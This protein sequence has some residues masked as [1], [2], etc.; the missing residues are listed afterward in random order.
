MRGL[1]ILL[2]G[3]V[4]FDGCRHRPRPNAVARILLRAPAPRV[5]G[6]SIPSSSS[7]EPL[8]RSQAEYLRDPTFHRRVVGAG[9]ASLDLD[10]RLVKDSPILELV[11]RDDDATRALRRC[12]ALVDLYLRERPWA[13][14]E[15]LL[16][17]TAPRAEV[18]DPCKKI[19]LE[20][21]R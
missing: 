8:L 18:L 16:D 12:Q 5:L 21:E 11:V 6:N 20:L 2:L 7:I 9:E 10:V 17:P 1:G 15:G 4:L 14:G 3:L 19:D 13:P